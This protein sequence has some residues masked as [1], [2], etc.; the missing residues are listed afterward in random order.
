MV[1]SHMYTGITVVMSLFKA[2]LRKFQGKATHDGK[3]TGQAE[4]GDTHSEAVDH[5]SSVETPFSMNQNIAYSSV[6]ISTHTAA[7]V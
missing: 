4:G 1:L 6:M 2:K 7:A 3:E 5:T